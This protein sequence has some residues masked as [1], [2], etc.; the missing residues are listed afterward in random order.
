M[1]D[2]YFSMYYNAVTKGEVNMDFL[3][4]LRIL[5]KE[6]G[7]NNSTLAKGSGIPY[8]TIDGLFKRGWEKAQ[9]STIQKI[10][11]FYNVSLDYMVYGANGLSEKALM[12]AARFDAISDYGRAI[13]ECV[14][15]QEKKF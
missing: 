4:R 2:N 3:Y 5:M 9:L 6:H 8:T 15:E 7:D 14:L 10:C 13:I 11:E 1:L 12:F